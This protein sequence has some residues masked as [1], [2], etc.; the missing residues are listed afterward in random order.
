MMMVPRLTFASLAPLT[1]KTLQP[2]KSLWKVVTRM[3][4]DDWKSRSFQSVVTGIPASVASVFTCSI[5]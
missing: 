5:K 2:L 4:F 3:A 1:P